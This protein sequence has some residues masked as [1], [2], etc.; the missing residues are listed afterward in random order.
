MKFKGTLGSWERD[1][2]ERSS[3]PSRCSDLTWGLGRNA[4]QRQPGEQRASYPGTGKGD[5]HSRMEAWIHFPG[6][7]SWGSHLSCVPHAASVSLVL[8][9][10]FVVSPLPWEVQQKHKNRHILRV[11]H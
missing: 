8:F 2:G 10:S 4:V 11:L 3:Q 5:W 1:T 7:T 6:A 9:L